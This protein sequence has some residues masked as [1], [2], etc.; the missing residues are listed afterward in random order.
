MYSDLFKIPLRAGIGAPK[1]ALIHLWIG[2]YLVSPSSGSSFQ[3]SSSRDQSVLGK[4]TDEHGKF[5]YGVEA[6]QRLTG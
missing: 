1:L 5:Q 4:E 3:I 2:P 6:G